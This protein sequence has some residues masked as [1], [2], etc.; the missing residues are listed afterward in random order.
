MM[1]RRARLLASLKGEPVDRPPVNFYEIDGSQ[2]PDDPDPFCIYSHPSWRPLLELARRRSDRILMRQVPF[3]RTTPD[4][5]EALT[6]AE[7]DDGPDQR[8]MTLTLRAGGR[9]FTRRTRRERDI[10]TL[11]T[12]EPWLKDLEDLQAWLDLPE[13]E[14]D[15]IPDTAAFLEAERRL[16]EDGLALIDVADPL[17]L[18]AQMFEMGQYT[19]IALSEPA[20]FRRLL[21]R[22]A[23][24]LL[25]EVEAVAR[26]LPGRLWRIYG[27]EYATPPYLP[28]RLFKEYVVPYDRPM[29]AAIQKPGG[30][31]RLHSHGRIRDV[32]PDIVATGC[33]ALD[34]I[35]PPPQ[36]DV[37][38]AEVRAQ[39]GRRLTLF[40]NL[41]ASDLEALPTPQFEHKIA[42]ALRDGTAGTGRGFV[43][44]PSACPYGRVLSPLALA[45]YRAMVRL[46][47]A[48]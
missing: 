20:L 45:N 48:G 40:G 21:D 9:T 32:L 36:G 25:P 11:W 30:V 39:Y 19:V 4:P 35:E 17:C 42:A 6:V 29:V 12:L 1:T 13:P 14:P 43:L 24:R 18:A 2:D 46:A 47:E 41:E 15:G 16:G 31:A 27:P 7:R 23:R 34:P 8:L 37:E 44:M 10:D 22:F 28:P 38:L 26:A 33:L 5:L 3:R